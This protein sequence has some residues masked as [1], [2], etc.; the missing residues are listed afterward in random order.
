MIAKIY[1]FFSIIFALFI[2]AISAVQAALISPLDGGS[3]YNIPH[4]A[5]LENQG[6]VVD[7]SRIRFL[8]GQEARGRPMII[9]A[10]S[11]NLAEMDL[12]INQIEQQMRQLTGQAEQLNFQLQQL[13][14]QLQRMQEDNEFRFQQLEGTGGKPRKQSNLTPKKPQVTENNQLPDHNKERIGDYSLSNHSKASE[15]MSLGRIPANAVGIDGA[16]GAP[17][18][19]TA[20][21]AQPGGIKLQPRDGEVEGAS[22][23]GVITVIPQD[24]YDLAY[25]FMLRGDY[26][27]AERTFSQFLETY[28]DDSLAPNAQYWL[29]EA[30]FSQGHYTAA[31][32]SFLQV[33]TKFGSKHHKA[34]DSLLKLGMALDKLGHR[35]KACATFAKLLSDFSDTSQ[36]IRQNARNAQS[37][38]KCV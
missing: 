36:A 13:Q 1:A 17:L 6:F 8:M 20:L 15:S 28:P 31:A 32:D 34:A 11:R 12:R 5:Q 19:L 23:A 24:E 7:R 9:L 4:S 35:D 33:F 3:R 18:D 30:Q 29:G 26:V 22:V 14:E 10:Q 25:G 38:A 2:Y 37:S 27:Q 21:L 16:P